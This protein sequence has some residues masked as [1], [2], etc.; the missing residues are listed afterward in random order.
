MALKGPVQRLGNVDQQP[1]QQDHLQQGWSKCQGGV[2]QAAGRGGQPRN[3]TCRPVGGMGGGPQL[4]RLATGTS[5]HTVLWNPRAL[6]KGMV[7]AEPPVRNY[8]TRAAHLGASRPHE[9]SPPLLPDC[10]AL[11]PAH[12]RAADCPRRHHAR[13]P[14]PQLQAPLVEGGRV[15]VVAAQRHYVVPGWQQDGVGWGGGWGRPWKAMHEGKMSRRV[16][17][18]GSSR[19]AHSQRRSASLQ[20]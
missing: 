3:C 5:M 18:R 1:A 17:S 4:A 10:S 16:A 7:P 20:S 6:A 19:I 8:A 15:A 11:R 12:Q 9:P 13:H 2:A 14:L